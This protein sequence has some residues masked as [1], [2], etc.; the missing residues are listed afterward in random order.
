[1]VT[2][3]HYRW[4]FIG[5][6]TDNKPTPDSSHKVT[7]GSTFYCSDTSKLYVFCQGTWYERTAPG[8]GGGGSEITVVQTTGTSTEDVMSQNAVTTLAALKENFVYN[9]STQTLNITM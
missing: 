6:S 1:M 4:D 3:N 2:D 7:D 8:G 9:T 5:L